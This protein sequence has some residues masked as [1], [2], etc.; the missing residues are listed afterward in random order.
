MYVGKCEQSYATDLYFWFVVLA[1]IYHRPTFSSDFE[2][3]S[4]SIESVS[5][6]ERGL[7]EMTEVLIPYM[8]LGLW[9]MGEA[10]GNFA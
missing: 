9:V 7:I 8:Y 3:R 6:F 4:F 1:H 2:Q 10:L 5:S